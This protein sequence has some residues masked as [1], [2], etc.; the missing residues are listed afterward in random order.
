MMT[1]AFFSRPWKN[2]YWY[3]T[4]FA[5][6]HDRHC[7][8]F[9]LYYFSK[10][11]AFLVT[12]TNRQFRALKL[13]K[14]QS[15]IGIHNTCA[16]LLNITSVKEWLLWCRHAV[17][18]GFVGPSEPNWMQIKGCSD[19]ANRH[20][21]G[22]YG[23]IWCQFKTRP[24]PTRPR[25]SQLNVAGPLT[26]AIYTLV[27]HLTPSKGTHKQDPCPVVAIH[28]AHASSGG[29]V[30]FAWFHSPRRSIDWVL[31]HSIS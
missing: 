17:I 5:E 30:V 28:P 13:W 7:R 21:V 23:C 16:V 2:I 6:S 22:P 27:R 18:Y 20:W 15:Q 11:N 9:M 19:I 24:F 3:S 10:H 14:S 12:S 8:W 25:H 29:V 26:F 31:V 1:D 4:R